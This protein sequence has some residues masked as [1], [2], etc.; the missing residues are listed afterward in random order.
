M[1]RQRTFAQLER[2]NIRAV[3]SGPAGVVQRW[4]DAAPERIIPGA[5]FWH[6]D[7]INVDSLRVSLEQG[8]V[9]VIGEIAV[10]YNG[11]APGDASLEP[12]WA[13]AEQYDV[14]V[15]IHIGLGPRGAVHGPYPKYDAS[16]GSPLLLDAVL[17]RHPKLRVYVM[18]AGWPMLDEMMLM[19]HMHPQLYVDVGV[20]DWYIPRKEF[21]YFLRR[22][23]DAGFGKQIMFGSDQMIWPERIGQAVEAIEVAEFLTAE[24]KRDIFYN[25]AARFLRFENG[26]AGSK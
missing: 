15:A 6:P 3:A 26:P 17:R 21:H 8:R 14:P 9:A 11:I 2:F 25:N 20:I 22:L 1:Y 16:V 7:E 24:Q 4:R 23:V 18:H 12:I 19:L 13:L 5:L 10:Q